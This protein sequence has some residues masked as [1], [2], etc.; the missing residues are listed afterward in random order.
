MRFGV[1]KITGSVISNSME[2]QLELLNRITD[3]I[4]NKMAS[5]VTFEAEETLK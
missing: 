2:L 4:S 5:S 1:S 3:S